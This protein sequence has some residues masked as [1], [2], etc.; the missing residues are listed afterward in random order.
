[1]VTDKDIQVK[2]RLASLAILWLM[3]RNRLFLR[4]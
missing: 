4:V 2:K 3:Y 1:M